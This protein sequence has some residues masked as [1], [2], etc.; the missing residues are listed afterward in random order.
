DPRL[1]LP[2]DTTRPS[3]RELHPHA[4]PPP[5]EGIAPPAESLGHGSPLPPIPR[6]TV[7][8]PRRAGRADGGRQQRTPIVSLSILPEYRH[9]LLRACFEPEHGARAPAAGPRGLLAPPRARCQNAR[10]GTLEPRSSLLRR[11]S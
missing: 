10:S 7:A 2:P 1:A 8:H 4:A 9:R 3:D 11:S 6:S 5:H